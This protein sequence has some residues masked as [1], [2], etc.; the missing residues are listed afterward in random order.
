MNLATNLFKFLIAI[1]PLLL[2]LWKQF[3]KNP[4]MI[5]IKRG[6]RFRLATGEKDDNT[7]DYMLDLVVRRRMSQKPNKNRRATSGEQSNLH[8]RGNRQR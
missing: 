7:Q 5:M 6:D 1:S 2:D 3:R 8:A 4:Q